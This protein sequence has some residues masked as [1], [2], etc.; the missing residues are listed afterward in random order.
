MFGRSGN[1]P[2]ISSSTTSLPNE[3]DGKQESTGNDHRDYIP[4]IQPSFVDSPQPVYST[5]VQARP[6]PFTTPVIP[7]FVRVSEQDFTPPRRENTRSAPSLPR[8]SESDAYPRS[9]AGKLDSGFERERGYSAPSAPEPEVNYTH[10]MTS[11]SGKNSGAS[12]SRPNGHVSL[13]SYVEPVSLNDPPG[14]SSRFAPTRTEK[15]GL[16]TFGTREP[17][18]SGLDRNTHVIK[19]TPIYAAR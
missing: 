7:S 5:K 16:D 9:F 17:P 18:N 15:L 6:P 2:P 19:P 1:H 3:M 13:M 10:N 14:Y 12:L 11:P 8:P 4:Q